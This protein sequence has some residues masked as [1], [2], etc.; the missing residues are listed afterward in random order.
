MIGVFVKFRYGDN[1]DERAIRMIAETARERF[2]GMRG[3][4]TK[5]FTFNSEK[6]EAINFYVWDSEDAA[7]AFFT[8]ELLERVTGI[9]GVRAIIEFVQ[10]ATLVE[11]VLA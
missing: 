4:H 10:I 11:N 9:Y 1:F 8:D 3:L 2:E 6:R 5:V 7:K